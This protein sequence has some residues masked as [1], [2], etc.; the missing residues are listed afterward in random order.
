MG[1]AVVDEARCLVWQGQRCD[2]CV[3]CCPMPG[4]L[5]LDGNRLTVDGGKCVGCGL[6]ERSCPTEPAAIRVRPRD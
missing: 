1:T 5:T 3:E 4:A 6:C 2:A